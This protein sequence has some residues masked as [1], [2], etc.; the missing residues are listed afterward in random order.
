MYTPA[1]IDV[2]SF[3]VDAL[4]LECTL[5]IAFALSDPIFF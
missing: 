1:P 3:P 2:T 4:R 5:N